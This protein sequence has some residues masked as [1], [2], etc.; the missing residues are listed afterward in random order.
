MRILPF[1][2]LLVVGL[3]M[4]LVAMDKDMTTD[5]P[6]PMVAMNTHCPMC[7]KPIGEN[8]AT[9]KMTIG[10][11]AEAKTCYMAMDSATCAQAFTKDPEQALRKQFGKDATGAKTPAK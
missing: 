2:S 7:T 10:E 5:K 9:V 11:G 8:P 6:S 3:G 4:P 1:L